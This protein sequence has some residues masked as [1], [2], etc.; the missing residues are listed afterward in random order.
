MFA[1]DGPDESPLGSLL[2]VGCSV[3]PFATGSVALDALSV[4]N[5][6]PVDSG[7]VL[8]SIAVWMSAAEEFSS[9]GLNHQYL[10]LSPTRTLSNWV[11][12][13]FDA[14]RDW[15]AKMSMTWSKLAGSEYS[16]LMKHET[17]FCEYRSWG[18]TGG[19]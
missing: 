12:I 19:W 8:F 2:V 1:G 10:D 18:R 17:D 3:G 7:T 15:V 14:A 4:A 13:R 5:R 16:G 6:Y 11:S 9:E